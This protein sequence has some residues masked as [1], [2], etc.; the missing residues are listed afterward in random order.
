MVTELPKNMT[1]IEISKPGGPEV[2]VPCT[3]PVP[4]PGP[5]QLLIKTAFAGVNRP[6]V[7]QRK[8]LYPPPPGASDLPGLEISGEVVAVG[9]D[10]PADMIG[11]KIC[12]LVAGGG[13]AEYCIAQAGQCLPV[14]GDLSMAEAAAIPETLFTTWHNIFERGYACEGETILVHGGTSG[15]GTM[16]IKLAKLFGITIIVTCGSDEKCDAARSI[17]ADH[18]INYKDSDFVAEVKRI[19]GGAGVNMV[20][21]MVA[22]DYV[23]RNLQ[24]LAEDGRHVTIAVQGGMSA[25]INMAQVMMR[26]LTLTGSTLRPR[27]DEFKALLCDEIRRTMWDA[28]GSGELRPEMAKSFSLTD[29]AAAHAFME[30]GDFVGKIVLEI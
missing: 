19:T 3:R 12:A 25:E 23:P 2:L 22:G 8:G 10:G 21:D 20:L 7:V 13:Y 5:G 27:S 4:V 24:C 16:A 17:G 11:R 29:A 18:A 9:A 26:R 6:D 15:I 14:T 28:V 30:A 1:A